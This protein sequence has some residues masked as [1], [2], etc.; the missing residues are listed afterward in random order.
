MS[1]PSTPKISRGPSLPLVW[2]VPL[3]ALA[4]AGW[5]VFREFRTRGPVVAIEFRHGAGVEPRKTMLEYRGVP[6]GT[7]TD[8][9][10]KPDLS[11][12]IVHLRLDRD[13]ADLAREGTQFWIVS[14]EIGFNGI[15]GLETLFTGSR[16][17][18]R[19]GKG[20]PAT[21]FVGLDKAPLLENQEEGRMFVLQA[22]RLGSISQGAPV[23]FR[24]L[25]VGVV[26]TVKLD[27]DSASV[28][29][30]I[31]VR[32]PYVK[33]V[34][35]STRFW[36]AGGISLRVNLLGAELRSTSLES[37]FTGG[38]AFATPDTGRELAPEARDGTL[39]TLHHE[40]EKE[41]L[42]WQPRIKISPPEEIPEAPARASAIAPLVK[43]EAK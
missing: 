24:E 41:W 17:R 27:D 38:V 8:V 33:L 15:R 12:V 22:E 34:R 30:R 7:V 32:P 26:E 28:L 19:P 18:V 39:F 31:R 21:E 1:T 40:A 10:L 13:A 9:Q 37:L 6:V 25:K 36:N 11:G 35:T 2:V 14:P 5:M 43:P 20:A 4:I 23:F 16:L 3:V 29:I 42:K